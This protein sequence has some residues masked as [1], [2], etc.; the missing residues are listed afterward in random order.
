MRYHTIISLV[1]LVERWKHKQVTLDE[2]FK[3]AVIFLEAAML[4]PETQ[5]NGAVV[6]F[7]M[8]G[9]SLQQTWQFTPPFAKRIVDWLQDSVPLR[10]KAI[11]IV[12]QP[13]IFNIVF[14]LFKPFLRE[15]LRSRIIFHGTDRE[16]LHKYMSP[17]VLPA[18]YGGILELPRID[19][20]QWYQL[21]VMCDAEYEAINSYGYKKKK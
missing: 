18:C 11:H 3:G 14:A 12:N 20:D 8:D 16:S 2:V 19:G 17:K 21:L 1:L 9:L 7:D 15:K 5:I 4:E 13:K 10:I 6:I